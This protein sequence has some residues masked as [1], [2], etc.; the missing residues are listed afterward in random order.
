MTAMAMGIPAA[1]PIMRP[2]LLEDDDFG[3]EEEELLSVTAPA[4]TFV[5]EADVV[6]WVTMTVEAAS[7]LVDTVEAAVADVTICEVEGDGVFE[8]L[9]VGEEQ[10]LDEG[11]DP[12]LAEEEP[13]GC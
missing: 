5:T 11:E 8:D 6:T 2:L 4:V 9:L 7:P 12:L 1:R 3:D 10:P 13:D